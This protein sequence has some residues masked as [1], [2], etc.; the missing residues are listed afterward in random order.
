M[1][2]GREPYKGEIEDGPTKVQRLQDMAFPEL[3]AGQLDDII[4]QRWQS[5][6]NSLQD[7]AATAKLLKEALTRPSA[8]ILSNKFCRR[9]RKECQLLVNEAVMRGL[10]YQLVHSNRRPFFGCPRRRLPER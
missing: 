9:R 2:R 3:S 10:I 1:T 4:N 7:L 6:F 5:T 8:T